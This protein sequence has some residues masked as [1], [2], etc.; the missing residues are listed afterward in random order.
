MHMRIIAVAGATLALLTVGASSA[1]ASNG[2]LRAGVG[3]ADIQPRTGYYLGGWTRADRVA[4][5]QHTRLFAD[6]MV[7]QRGGRKVALVAAQLFAVPAGLQQHV[8][9]ALADRGFTTSN[10]LISA[11]HTHGGPGG[12]ANFPTYNTAAPSLQ[13]LD[14]PIS[15]VELLDPKPTDRQLYT[16]LV[17]RIATAIRRADADLA[18]AK[19][20]WGDSRLTNVTENRS[21]EA[22]LADHGIEKPFGSA[23]PDQDPDGRLHTIDPAVDVL[24]VD[25]LARRRG[26][27]VRVPIGAWSNFANHGTVTKSE[28]EAY[29]GDH[30]AA[31]SR[32][33]AERVR[34]AGDVPSRQAV[35]N[36]YGN[37]DEGDQSAGLSQTGPA[38]SDA[39]GRAEARA[40]VAAW[41]SAGRRLS[42]RPTL[43]L[44]ATR[45]CFCGQATSD[46]GNVAT[47]GRPGV[48]FFTGS[49]EGRGP[50]FDVTRVPLEGSRAPVASRDQG[51][52]LVVPAGGFPN[53]AP[54]MVVR[55]AN[56]VIASMPGEPSKEEG[57][58]VRQA[59]LAASGRAGVKRV[60]IAGLANEY[61]SYITT[62][63]EYGAQH[64]EGGSTLFGPHEGAFLA[65]QLGGLAGR[66]ARDEPAPAPY[67]FDPTNG[68]RPDGPAYGEGA[69]AGGIVE[70]PAASYERLGHAGMSW[71]GGPQGLDR[72][73]DRAFVSVQRRARGRWLPVDDDLGLAML[74]R[75]DDQGRYG[76]Y[77]EIPRDARRGAYRMV[78]TANRY[79]LASRPFAVADAN[80]LRA[81]QVPAAP[82]QM[83]V[84]LRYPSAIE[85]VDLTSRP[86][87]TSGGSVAFRVNGREVTISRAAGASTFS[88]RVPAGSSVSVPAGA[89]HDRFGNANGTALTLR[90][91]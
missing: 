87:S 80:T 5:G 51:E 39:V 61:L 1:S 23:N 62:R 64:Y 53:A 56:G 88:L 84:R 35:V 12:F 77:W 30:H 19:A 68:V 17:Q 40:M 15:F 74:W 57:V 32:V 69:A 9:E 79:R 34:R 38:G 82:G 86:R 55:V 89:A 43:D 44:R 76:A 18:P 70:Q 33:F 58:R 13:T 66:M 54:I 36:V 41:R 37:S 45:I 22:H 6:A 47:E 25:K 8:A 83:A 52:K 4:N 67:P 27:R 16:F 24:R 90:G 42:A 72:P 31:A 7:L 85:N 28:F 2:A 63:E 11:S 75:V 46:G 65:D 49:E 71:Q 48:P 81:E 60:V 50:L 91:G 59:V 78:V 20:A 21:L 14:R 26:R 29:N 10:V 73:V 3:Q